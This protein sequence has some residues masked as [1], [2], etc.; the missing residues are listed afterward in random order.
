MC[1]HANECRARCC[2][3][4][5]VLPSVYLSVI[6]SVWYCIWVNAHIGKLFP[7]SGRVMTLVSSRATAVIKFQGELPQWGVK[8]TGV[9]EKFVIL[10][11]NHRLSRKWYEIGP[12]LLWI[13]KGKSQVANQSVSVPV[14]SSDLENWDTR[15]KFVADLSY[16]CSYGLT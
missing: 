1:Q 8:C 16:I 4:K 15:V 3:G 14:T 9:G 5:S 2:Y 13:T 12:W 7:P 10:D 6:L 11:C